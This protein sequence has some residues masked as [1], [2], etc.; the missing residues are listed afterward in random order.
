MA[1]TTH[2]YKAL[3]VIHGRQSTLRGSEN[4]RIECVDY[5][6]SLPTDFL[7]QQEGKR[8]AGNHICMLIDAAPTSQYL[9]VSSFQMKS[10]INDDY[11]QCR[12][13]AKRL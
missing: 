13:V 8:I 11:W 3:R 9:Q 12:P 4:E 10:N 5:S 7:F 2:T 6:R 1:V